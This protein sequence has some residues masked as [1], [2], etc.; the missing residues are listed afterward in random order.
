M[1]IL[2]KAALINGNLMPN[3]GVLLV[4]YHKHQA[5]QSRGPIC[6]GGVVTVLAR[7]LR[8][9][10][11][12]IQPLTGSHRLGL[13]TLRACGMISKNHGRYFFD[14]PG[15]HHLIPAPLPNGLF[16]IEDGRLCFDA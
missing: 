10:L 9:N 6:G 1:L 5:L 4:F 14:I 3:L 11:G 8:I 15:A 12:N 7:A 13:S 16:S 2:A